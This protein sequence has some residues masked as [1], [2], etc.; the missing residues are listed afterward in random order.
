M[1]RH[2]MLGSN[3]GD[4]PRDGVAHGLIDLNDLCLGLTIG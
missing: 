1:D 2:G 4:I 3:A